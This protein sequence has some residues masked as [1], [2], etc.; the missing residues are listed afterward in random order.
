MTACERGGKA[1]PTLSWKMK[2]SKRKR[3]MWRPRLQRSF[4]QTETEERLR[5]IPAQVSLLAEL[6]GYTQLHGINSAD[7]STLYILQRRE[8]SERAGDERRHF[9][10]L[11]FSSAAACLT[12]RR[13]PQN[14][15]VGKLYS[16]QKNIRAVRGF[17]AQLNSYT[18]VDIES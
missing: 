6:T 18:K 10:R 9:K 14:S 13:R 11:R 8:E 7:S 17:N 16:T 15:S 4:R 3:K 1:N 5:Q 2:R 12:G